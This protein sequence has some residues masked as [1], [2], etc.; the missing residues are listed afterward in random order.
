MDNFPYSKRVLYI[1]AEKQIVPLMSLSYII[2]Q[3][4]K[5]K[6]KFVLCAICI[7][8]Y[9]GCLQFFSDFSLS[10]IKMGK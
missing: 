10:H 3:E 2:K 7:L 1:R 4:N 9:R 8:I 5:N 6:N